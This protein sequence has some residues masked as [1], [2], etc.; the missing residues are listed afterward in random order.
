MSCRFAS[1]NRRARLGNKPQGTGWAP[2]VGA[3]VARE[4]KHLAD[5]YINKEGNGITEAFVKYA[6]PLVGTLPVIGSF[7]EL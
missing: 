1:V 4:T 7:E 2:R 6:R 5:E 3:N